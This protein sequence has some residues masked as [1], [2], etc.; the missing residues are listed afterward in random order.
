MRIKVFV[1]NEAGSS[2]KNYHDEKALAFRF[3]KHVSRL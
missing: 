2:L 3:V 1:Q